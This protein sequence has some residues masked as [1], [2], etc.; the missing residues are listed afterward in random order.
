[1]SNGCRASMKPVLKGMDSSISDDCLSSNL[2]SLWE[3]HLSSTD[4]RILIYLNTEEPILH[5]FKL[6]CDRELSLL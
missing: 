6:G 4:D 1:M 5:G 2:S 3:N